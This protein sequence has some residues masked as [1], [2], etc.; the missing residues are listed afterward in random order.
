MYEEISQEPS[1][2]ALFTRMNAQVNAAVSLR[3]EIMATLTFK[4]FCKGRPI[5]EIVGFVNATVLRNTTSGT[6]RHRH[7][8]VSSSTPISFEIDGYG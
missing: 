5:G 1:G 6:I 3:Y 4:F 7:E 2:S 8:C